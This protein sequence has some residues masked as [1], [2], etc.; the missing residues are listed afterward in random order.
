[1]VGFNVII[2]NTAGYEIFFCNST[3]Q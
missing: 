3:A 1:V 2:I